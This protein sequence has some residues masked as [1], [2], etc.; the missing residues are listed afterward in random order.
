MTVIPDEL[1][2]LGLEPAR[3]LEPTDTEVAAVL[4]RL[5]TQHRSRR[6]RR[7]LVL[8][9]MAAILVTAGAGAATGVLPIG[10][11]LPTESISGKG[12]PRYTSK[13]TVVATGETPVAGRWQATIAQSNYGLC[14]GLELIDIEPGALSEGCG[15]ASETFDA[16]SL[17]GGS[18]MP[19]TTLVYGP[20]P[21][22]AVAVRATGEGGFTQSAQT[23]EGPENFQGDFYVMEIPRNVRDVEIAW[24]DSDGRTQGPGIF[25]PSTIRY[26]GPADP[27]LPH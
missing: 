19:D 25:V 5:P 7:T 14:F 13:R 15:G 8:G 27:D 3:A 20:A 6:H 4:T 16:A 12:E 9:L 22:N 10:T 2:R 17:G 18:S 26:K 11:E 1:L 23:Q 21:E 24:L